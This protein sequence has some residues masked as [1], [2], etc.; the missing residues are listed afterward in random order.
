[1]AIGVIT[2]SGN[3]A[4]PGFDDA[5]VDEVRTPFG[6]ARVSSGQFH[7]VELLQRVGRATRG[8]RVRSST[9]PTS[10]P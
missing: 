5:E 9:G 3:Y 6:S 1:M 2:G 4:L 10:G 7:G 8:C